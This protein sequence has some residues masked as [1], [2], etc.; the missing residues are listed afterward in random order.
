MQDGINRI[1]KKEISNET[2]IGWIRISND[3]VDNF[4]F[5]DKR[6]VDIPITALRILANIISIVR[7]EQFR[8]EDRPTQ[9]SLFEDDFET[10]H[11]TF[12]RIKIRNTEISPSRSYKQIAK[13]YEFLTKFRMDWYSS[14]NSQG[15]LIKT[16]GGLISTPTKDERGYTVFLISSYWLKKLIVLPQYNKILFDLA[17]HLTNNKQVIFAIWL[18]RIPEDGTIL[19]LDTFNKKFGLEYE[20]AGD[21]CSKFL[22]P[23]KKSLDMVNDISFNYQFTHDRIKIIPYKK[24]VKR[25]PALKQETRISYRLSYFKKRFKLDDNQLYR[26]KKVFETDVKLVEASYKD[27][28]KI[29]RNRKL[30]STHFV[31]EIFLKELQTFI[32]KNYKQSKAAERFPDG[33]PILLE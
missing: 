20:N 6:F 19:K 2:Q 28:V 8:P 15:R 33:F 1:V 5:E 26:L 11:N 21:F 31:G 3:F 9:L 10:E 27:F 23:I 14:K 25:N 18:T 29:N 12:A 22:R 13:A 4:L 7:D 17:Y 24:E 32:I 30:K 16:Y